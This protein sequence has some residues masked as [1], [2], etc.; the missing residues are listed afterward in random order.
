MKRQ[1]I[2]ELI[3]ALIA[4]RR[5]SIAAEIRDWNEK[6]RGTMSYYGCGGAYERQVRAKEKRE[7]ELEDLNRF[8]HQ[9]LWKT[10]DIDHVRVYT[11]YCRECGAVTMTTRFTSGD[12]HECGSCRHMLFRNVRDMQIDVTSD[13]D[14]GALMRRLKEADEEEQEEEAEDD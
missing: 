6:I 10:V 8:E 5:K 3:Q 4:Q 7:R 1:D 14:F 13:C 2:R 11:W 12:W 9:L